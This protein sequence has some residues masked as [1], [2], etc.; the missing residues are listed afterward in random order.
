MSQWDW[1]PR[2]SIPGE[3]NRRVSCRYD[4][5]FDVCWNLRRSILPVISDSTFAHLLHCVL[6]EDNPTKKIK[7]QEMLHDLRVPRYLN[8]EQQHFF[9]HGICSS[10]TSCMPRSGFTSYHDVA[11]WFLIMRAPLRHYSLRR[12]QNLANVDDLGRPELDDIHMG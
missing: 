12:N 5:F 6:S 11:I 4:Q 7:R 3:R 2:D 8:L 1:I 9:L 10:S